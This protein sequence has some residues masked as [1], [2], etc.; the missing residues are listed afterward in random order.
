ML[1]ATV[2]GEACD[3][4]GLFVD[5]AH[6]AINEIVE[7]IRHPIVQGGE[8]E[9]LRRLQLQLGLK[10]GVPLLALCVV[11]Q[12]L[13]VYKQ[14]IKNWKLYFALEEHDCML[15]TEYTELYTSASAEYCNTI[16]FYE[17]LK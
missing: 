8:E 15:P 11:Q 7:A 10:Q 5:V 12:E 4:R 17:F 14:A 16:N 3:L 13:Q 6:Q 2:D 1:L 9:H